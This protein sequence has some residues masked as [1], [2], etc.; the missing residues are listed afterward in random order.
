[1]RMRLSSVCTPRE[2]VEGGYGG[3]LV[4]IQ[5]LTKGSF[6]LALIKQGEA[7]PGELRERSFGLQC[8]H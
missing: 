8:S 5:G 7:L 3:Y 6:S 4:S 2:Y 1:M